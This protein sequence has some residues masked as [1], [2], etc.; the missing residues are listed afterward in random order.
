M[1]SLLNMPELDEEPK[2]HHSSFPF[3]L[4]Q[5]QR[6]TQACAC[7]HRGSFQIP[8]LSFSRAREGRFGSQGE[9]EPRVKDKEGCSV[10]QH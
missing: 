9:Q 3:V 4:Q 5:I 8:F 2:W 10:L 7:R 6:Y 1:N